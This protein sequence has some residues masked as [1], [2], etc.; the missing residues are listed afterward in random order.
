MRINALPVRG[1][2]LASAP[3]ESIEQKGRFAH[4][5]NADRLDLGAH[6]TLRVAQHGGP[7]A[8]RHGLV[9]QLGDPGRVPRRGDLQPGHHLQDRA[10]PHAVVTGAVPAGHPGPVERDRHRQPVQR[11]VHQQL[12][13]GAVQERRVDRDHRVQA[14]HGQ[15]GRAG[16]RV[17]LGDADV[18]DP[19]R[20]GPRERAEAGRVQH[21]CGDRDHV[22]APGA[23]R[24]QLLAEHLGPGTARHRRA[25]APR[26]PAV[27]RAPRAGSPPR[28]ARPARSRSPSW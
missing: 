27:R 24:G 20:E 3:P 11:H 25:A 18:E 16:H 17:L 23:D 7:V 5:Y 9:E 21:R 8:H 28:S 26:S 12:V 10:V 2:N 14:A 15:A 22:G 13:E 19:V 1:Q 4:A 6:R